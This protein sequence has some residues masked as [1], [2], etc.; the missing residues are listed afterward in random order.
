M[1]GQR[2]RVPVKAGY[3][4]VPDDPADPPR[5]LGTRCLDCGEHFFTR[6]AICAKCMSERTEDVLLGV[7]MHRFGM[8]AEKSNA[9]MAR[10][11]G[12]AALRD[13]GLSFRD[14][15]AAYVGYIFAPVMSAARTMKEFGLTGI[16]VQRIENASATGSAAFREACFAVESGRHD[17]VMVLGFDKMTEMIQRSGAGTDPAY[18]ED[19]ILPA[20][21][22][23]MWATRR[24]HER[25]T[26]PEHLAAIAAMNFNNGALNPMSQRQPDAPVTVEKVLASRMVAW[27]LTAMMSCPIGDGAACAIVGRPDMARRLRPGRPAVRVLA[28]ELQPARYARGY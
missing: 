3:F 25:G 8:W 21:F 9:D 7:G 6:R 20:A 4:T 1:N 13:A 5:L 19:S 12:L 27:P 10:E 23:A 2:T 15:Q 17:V 11:A 24:I 26:K 16:P 28:S 14:V 22:F 18:L